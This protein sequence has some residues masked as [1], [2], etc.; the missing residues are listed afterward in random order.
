MTRVL[1]LGQLLNGPVQLKGGWRCLDSTDGALLFS[2]RKSCS[3]LTNVA[4]LCRAPVP[5]PGLQTDE[6][7]PGPAPV[8][9]PNAAP[10]QRR[11][12]L[13]RRR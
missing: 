11:L 5:D 6:P 8:I 2:P 13:I 9:E 10:L 4:N 7:D 3:V 12:D 1:A